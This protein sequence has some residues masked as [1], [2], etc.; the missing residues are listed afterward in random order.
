MSSA[1]PSIILIDQASTSIL[2]TAA[3]PEF[4]RTIRV[5]LVAW[6]YPII[7]QNQC[8]SPLLAKLATSIPSGSAKT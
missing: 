5:S 6:A 8:P 4:N 7:D 1:M 2:T 3:K